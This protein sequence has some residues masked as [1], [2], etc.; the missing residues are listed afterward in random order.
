MITGF[1]LYYSNRNYIN[2]KN[3]VFI[4]KFY[5]L[6]SWKRFPGYVCAPMLAHETYESK[7]FIMSQD[8]IMLSDIAVIII[9]TINQI[10]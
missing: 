3:F 6:S 1:S 7:L 5:S 4:F 8:A 10:S 9:T 2:Q